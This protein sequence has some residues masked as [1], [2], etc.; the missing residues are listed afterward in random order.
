MY[1]PFFSK[2]Y[3]VV[4]RI[5]KGKVATYQQV[6]RLAGSPNAMRAVGTAMAKNP[7]MTSIP[8][9]RVVGSDSRMHGYSAGQGVKTKIEMLKKE[10]VLFK[11][12]KVDLQKNIWKGRT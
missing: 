9:H 6:A 5:P 11:G 10:G 4:S 7:D 3:K 12:T 8:C 1:S 2:V